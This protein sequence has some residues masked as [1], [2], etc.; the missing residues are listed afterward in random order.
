MYWEMSLDIE[1]GRR[2]FDHN[3]ED[4]SGTLQN[5]HATVVEDSAGKTTFNGSELNFNVYPL[6]E[7][8]DGRDAH[9]VAGGEQYK[10]NR[11]HRFL[12]QQAEAL[13]TQAGLSGK[14]VQKVIQIVTSINSGA[15]TYYGPNREGGG[16]DAHILA[17]IVEV[18]N[19]NLPDHP[20]YE[21]FI[22]RIQSRDEFQSVMK[23]VGMDLDNVH[24]AVAQ[25]RKQLR[26]KR[27]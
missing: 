20:D 13:A 23:E 4:G 6:D 2:Q 25:L 18:A 16:Q 26:K 10:L 3:S 15:F 19:R 14:Q 21:R 12:E 5:E 1:A 17:A 24:G 8:N 7:Y 27:D 11:Y 9:S 22:E